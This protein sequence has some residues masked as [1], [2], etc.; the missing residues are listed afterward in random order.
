MPK[1]YYTN[2]NGYRQHYNP[3]SPEAR[4]SGFSPVHRDVA[5]KK[6]NRNIKPYEVVHHKDGNKLNNSWDNI[7]IMSRSEHS[8]YHN[9]KRNEANNIGCASIIAII[10]LI[11]LTIFFV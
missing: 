8:R 10:I 7:E 6:Y 1:R 5:R 4:K 3:K 11:I 9:K 2:K